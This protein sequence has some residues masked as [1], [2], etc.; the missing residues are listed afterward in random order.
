LQ[1]ICALQIFVSKP[2]TKITFKCFVDS[3]Y[4]LSGLALEPHPAPY[5]V[6]TGVISWM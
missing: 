2:V 3:D 4:K 1:F 5:A 6:G